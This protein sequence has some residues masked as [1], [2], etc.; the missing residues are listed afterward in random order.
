MGEVPNKLGNYRIVQKLGAGGMA[1]V[2]EAID[3]RLQRHVAL[4]VLPLEFA[5]DEDRKRRFDK[6][7][8]ATANLRHPNIITVYDVGFD[9]GYSYYTM[10]LMPGGDLKAKIAA[11][12]EHQEVVRITIQIA[13]ALAYAH[14]QNFVHRDLKPENILFDS[15]GNA[16]VTDLGIAK[17]VGETMT[18]TGLSIGTPY[19]MSPEQIRGKRIDGR[20]DLYSLGVLLYRILTKENLFEADDSVGICMQHV[21]E[22]PPPLPP[23]AKKF[24]PYLDN[25]LA[26]NPDDRYPT[27]RAFIEDFKNID[28]NS[29]PQ[30]TPADLAQEKTQI[31]ATEENIIPGSNTASTVH[32]TTRLIE[33]GEHKRLP[34]P[35]IFSVALVVLVGLGSALYFSGIINTNTS[36]N[37]ESKPVAD[38]DRPKD[39]QSDEVDNDSNSVVIHDGPTAGNAAL[40]LVTIPTTANVSFNK[41]LLGSTPL[42]MEKL[43]AGTQDFLIEKRFYKPHTLSVTLADSIVSKENVTLQLGTGN[44]TVISTTNDAWIKLNG[45]L[46]NQNTPATLQN[47]TA[48]EYQLEIG[49]EDAYY[50]AT[51]EIDVDQ[52]L[53]LRPALNQGVLVNYG[54]QWFTTVELLQKANNYLAEGKR[55]G[56]DNNN[57]L[58]IYRILLEHKPDNAEAKQGIESIFVGFQKTITEAIANKN[59]AVADR[60]IVQAKLWFPI[61]EEYAALEQQIATLRSELEQQTTEQQYLAASKIV[62]EQLLRKHFSQAKVALADL[63]SRFA[64]FTEQNASLE[65]KIQQA[66]K[67][68]ADKVLRYSGELAVVVAGPVLI[69]TRNISIPALRVGVHEVTFA[70]WENCVNDGACTHRPNDQGWGRDQRPVVDVNY[71]DITEEYLPWL[72]S[73]TGLAFRLPSEAE[74]EYLARANTDSTYYWGARP[75]AAFANGDESRGWVRDDFATTAPVGQLQANRF[76]LY[77]TAGNVW[78]WVADCAGNREAIPA[79]GG[80]STQGNCNRRILKGGSWFSAARFLNPRERLPV[81]EVERTNDRGFR[82]VVEY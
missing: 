4:K 6:E 60:E 47:L 23:K 39:D 15:H 2:Y 80:P 34:K 49:K 61:R 37:G 79:N 14:E 67:A 42:L 18:Q 17:F 3:E 30:P 35:F 28:L 16:I 70:Q 1:D 82:L 5:R 65:R 77:D 24:Q 8:K 27:A 55:V 20:S 66:E 64:N 52:T 32:R 7:V 72:K 13:E 33:Q 71:L 81:A 53:T 43:P 75:N 69:E 59:L 21:N 38:D 26:K 46:Q 45:N 36:T 54:D 73:K 22:P 50:S 68:F 74:W 25:L 62:E 58:R 48:G 57:A 76:G 11:D 40:Q 78:E 19:Y 44:L 10:E 12:I 31:Y 41:Q 63:Q 29:A 51:I 56:E 9:E